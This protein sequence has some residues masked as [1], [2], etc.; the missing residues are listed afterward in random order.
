[1]A[2]L[3][4][5]AATG[6]GHGPALSV[7][8]LQPVLMGLPVGVLVAEAPSGRVLFANPALRR[9]TGQARSTPMPNGGA[10]HP[11]GRRYKRA[12]WPLQRVLRTGQ[13]VLA[14]EVDFRRGDA[15][16]GTLCVT[17]VPVRAGA[18]ELGAVV[19]LVWE[20]VERRD[21]RRFLMA[22]R[23]V[24]QAL[25]EAASVEEA[26][27]RVLGALCLHLGWDWGFLFAVDAV[28]AR[29]RLVAQGRRPGPV[30]DLGELDRFEPAAGEG[31]AGRVWQEGRSRWCP[32][33][34]REGDCPWLRAAAAAG[35][36]SCLGVPIRAGEAVLGV[37]ALGSPRLRPPDPDLAAVV[38]GAAATLGQWLQRLR[39]EEELHHSNEQL[40]ALSRSSPAA[41]MALDC[42]GRVTFWNAA[43]ERIF[44]WSEA[45]MLGQGPPYCGLLTE[46]Q[47]GQLEGLV[48]RVLVDG[49]SVSGVMARLRRR[50]GSLLDVSVSVA[51]LFDPAGRVTG[52]IATY[53]DVTERTRFLQIAA[54]E[55][56]N[57]MASVKGIVSLVRRR[58]GDGRPADDLVPLLEVVEGEIDRLSATLH[59]ILEGFRVAAGQLE[60]RE[61]PVD[62]A[63]VLTA[64]A[65]PFVSADGPHR[66]VVTGADAGPVWVWGDAR[67]L[68]DVFR[69]LLSNARKYAPDGGEVAVRL[70]AGPSHARVAVRDHGLGIPP[71]ELGRIF[72]AF[73]RGS[74][75]G[76]R[77]PGG[78]GLGL[79]LCRDIVERHRGRIW[80]AN[81]EGG[82]AVFHVELPLMAQ[83]TAS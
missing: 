65:R 29:L 14:E 8:L 40:R 79:F 38:E 23:A 80:A 17:A 67:R 46:A 70:E 76:P 47:T 52:M 19:Q 7:A 57:P 22:E 36:R 9:I 58:L 49:E 66:F 56:R 59:E 31:F 78:L 42:E 51:P 26:G 1:V 21:A 30:A 12:E 81:A 69:N 44:G 37:L 5:V 3:S 53:L 54:H 74:N 27:R 48:R 55:L 39:V 34:A 83:G 15:T 13:P 71:A 20:L 45:E 6:P 75:L 41:A 16:W 43:A 2:E 4:R 60:I 50:N 73:H 82:G 62:L 25:T 64:A 33:A 61:G 63:G 24:V 10:Y 35:V 11:D 77:D 18:G 68:E 32:D 28:T 72:E